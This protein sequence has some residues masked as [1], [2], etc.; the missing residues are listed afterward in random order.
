[1]TVASNGANE[2]AQ[3][4]DPV[5]NLSKRKFGSQLM[6]N[7]GCAFYGNSAFADPNFGKTLFDPN[8]I[9]ALTSKVTV[10]ALSL[11]EQA[12]LAAFYQSAAGVAGGVLLQFDGRDY[13]GTD[14]QTQIAPADIEEARAIV[15]FLAA[16]EVAQAPGAMI[17]TS[18][19][20]AIANGTAAVTATINGANANLNAPRAQGDAGGAYNAG[21]IIFYDPKGS[22]PS[23]RFTGKLETSSGNATIEPVVGSSANAVAGLFLS[24]HKWIN[25]GS[26]PQGI[27]NKIQAAN[28]AS[29]P[30]D[31]VVI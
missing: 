16:C 13:H 21:L 15:M 12:Q 11:A 17:Y 6:S 9:A 8:N 7:A 22:P 5:F 29:R 23:P 2:I 30:D 25:G 31:V 19:G 3:A 27:L 4:L 24:A 18:N 14:P 1:L 20:Q 28:L 10:G 26:I